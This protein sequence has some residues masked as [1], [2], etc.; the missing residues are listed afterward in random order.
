MNQMPKQPLMPGNAQGASSVPLKNLTATGG[1]TLENT[2][3]ASPKKS[4]KTVEVQPLT[5]VFVPLETVKPGKLPVR[6]NFG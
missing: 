1:Q 3:T 4:P 6:N 5:D 2:P